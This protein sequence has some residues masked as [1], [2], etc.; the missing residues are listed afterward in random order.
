MRPDLM[1]SLLA[2]PNLLAW[3]GMISWYS[4][5]WS[6]LDY[7][8]DTDMALLLTHLPLLSCA[9]RRMHAANW[10][11]GSISGTSRRVG[12]ATRTL[13]KLGVV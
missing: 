9:H 4:Q 1:A 12:R 7:H 2:R 3:H 8:E 13:F 5:A 10:P 11:T 6:A